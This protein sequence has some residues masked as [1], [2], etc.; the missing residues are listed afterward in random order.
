MMT[1]RKTQKCEHS[2]LLPRQMFKHLARQYEDD[3]SDN[4]V[5]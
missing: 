3:D 4:S 5:T 1:R 2:V